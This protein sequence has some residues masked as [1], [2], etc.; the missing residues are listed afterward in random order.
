M[1]KEERN[2]LITLPLIILLGLLVAAAGSRGAVT[3]LGAPL[4][5]FSIS[6][7]FL[8]QWLAFIPAYLLQT[9]IFFDLVGSLTYI[10]VT[11]MALLLSPQVGGRSLVT[12]ESAVVLW[13]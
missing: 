10:G 6:I 5:A 2:A 1:K 7:A 3:V 8:V 9:E 4:F 12:Y 11:I 13:R